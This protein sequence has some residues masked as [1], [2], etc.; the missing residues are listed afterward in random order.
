MLSD[1]VKKTSQAERS[2]N[3]RFMSD[4]VYVCSFQSKVARIRV[5]AL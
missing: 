3:S 2:N 5:V 1:D 4:L